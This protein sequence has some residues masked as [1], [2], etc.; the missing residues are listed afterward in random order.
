M[1]ETITLRL[2]NNGA[3]IEV[4]MGVS[5]QEVLN[6][7]EFERPYPILVARVNIRLSKQL[8]KLQAQADELRIFEEKI[9]HLADQMLPL[10]LDDGVKVNYAKLGE[11]VRGI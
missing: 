5:L 4:A 9:H 7:V 3:S 8:A 1:T 11:V 6:L 10:D 2:V